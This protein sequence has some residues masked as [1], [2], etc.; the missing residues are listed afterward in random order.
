MSDEKDDDILSNMIRDLKLGDELKINDDLLIVRVHG[1]YIVYR[2]IVKNYN[3][4][5]NFIPFQ[6]FNKR[7]S[8]YFS[9]YFMGKS[10]ES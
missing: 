9:N 6:G 2:N 4:V 1:G 7:D 8:Q 10:K 5:S 3:H